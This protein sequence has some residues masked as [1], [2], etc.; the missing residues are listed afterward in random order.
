[1][2]CLRSML[3]LV[4][5]LSSTSFAAADEI[6]DT[7]DICSN[8]N[9]VWLAAHPQATPRMFMPQNGIA[10]PSGWDTCLAFEDSWRGHENL[11]CGALTVS[12]APIL[13]VSTEQ[14]SASTAKRLYW[15]PQLS[16][17]PTRCRKK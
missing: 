8:N 15:L 12:S 5:V 2:I 7:W 3:F 1:M 10:G 14:V 4:V 16:Q 11:K 13:C 17:G 9:F 6:N